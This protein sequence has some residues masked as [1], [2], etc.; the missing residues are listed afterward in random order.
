VANG[1][2]GTTTHSRHGRHHGIIVVTGGFDPKL[3]K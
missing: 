1:S 2:R 3:Y